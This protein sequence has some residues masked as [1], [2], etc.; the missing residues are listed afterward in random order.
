MLPEQSFVKKKKIPSILPHFH[1]LKN[2]EFKQREKFWMK[3][4]KTLN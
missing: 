1:I 4:V 3:Y 2:R